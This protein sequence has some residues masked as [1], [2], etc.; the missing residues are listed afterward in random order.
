MSGRIKVLFVH[1][2]TGWGGAPFNLLNIINKLDKDKYVVK[3]LFVKQSVAVDIFKKH[4]IR[5]EVLNGNDNWFAHNSSAKTHFRHLLKYVKIYRDWQFVAK[6]EALEYLKQQDVDILHLNSHVLTSWACA[7]KKLGINVVLHNQETI[8]AGYFGFRYKIVKSLISKYSDVIINI[9]DDAENSLG[10]KEK[11]YKVY[12]FVDI[13]EEYEIPNSD[14]CFRVL[15][16]GGMSEIKG[17]KTVVQSLNYLNSNIIIQFAGGLSVWNSENNL[18]NKLKNLIK[19]TVYRGTYLPIKK[20]SNSKQAEI[21]GLLE[22]PLP[23]L[24][25]CDILITPFTV[26]HFSRPAIEAMAYA[27]PVIGTDV[28]GMDEIINHNIN[29]LIVEKNNPKALAH[30]INYLAENPN[31]AKAMGLKGREKAVQMFSPEP[32]IKKIENI[33]QNLFDTKN[34]G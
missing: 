15:Y 11:T 34:S 31:L 28:E 27:K 33:Y 12:N 18:T 29:G 22:N 10:I 26:P 1:H 2:A 32:N 19:L 30:A 24:K 9:S 6:K 16:L 5:C 7:A 8:A 17:F 25:K 3:V 21:L 4:G 23:F 14:N 13:P 20:M